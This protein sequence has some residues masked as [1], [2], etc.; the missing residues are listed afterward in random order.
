MHAGLARYNR[1]ATV[2]KHLPAAHSAMASQTPD[3][4]RAWAAKCPTLQPSAHAGLVV[5]IGVAD[6]PFQV[7]LFARDD[8]V[9]DRGN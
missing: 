2:A 1:W 4:V 5:S 3:W 6:P 8:A 9:S 7:R